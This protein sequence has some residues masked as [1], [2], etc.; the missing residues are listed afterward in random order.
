M[1]AQKTSKCFTLLKKVERGNLLCVTHK[2]GFVKLVLY[3]LMSQILTN[4][5]SNA[6]FIQS[7]N[8]FCQGV[9]LFLSMLILLSVVEL[10]FN[11]FCVLL[12]YDLQQL[13][14]YICGLI[15]IKC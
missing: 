13:L 6:V 3:P 14:K 2:N 4:L 10:F 12:L 7:Q 1:E 8:Y 5:T 11:V 15:S 9:L